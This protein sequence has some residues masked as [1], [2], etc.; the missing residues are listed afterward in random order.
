M[1][2]PLAAAT[3]SGKADAP[4]PPSGSPPRAGDPVL[5][6]CEPRSSLTKTIF[7]TLPAAPSP[8]H[9]TARP[10]GPVTATQAGAFSPAVLLHGPGWVTVLTPPLAVTITSSPSSTAATR[11]W[12][13]ITP[14]PAT[15]ATTCQAPPASG[16]RCKLPCVEQ[17]PPI[18]QGPTAARSWPS[19]PSSDSIEPRG[20]AADD[21]CSPPSVVYHR[22]LPNTNPSEG[23]ANRIPHTAGS[24]DSDRV[25]SGTTGAGSPRQLAPRFRVRRIDVHGAFAHGAVPRTN[26]SC[27]ETNVTDR[28]ANPI[29]TGPPAGTVTVDVLADV[30]GPAAPVEA[31]PLAADP[32]VALGPPDAAGPLDDAAGELA[33][34]PPAPELDAPQAVSGTA[35]SRAAPASPTRDARND[36]FMRSP[37]AAEASYG[38]GDA[39]AGSPVRGIWPNSRSR[40][41]RPA[42][43]G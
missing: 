26:A 28:A 38:Y 43:V 2:A 21:Q 18:G 12:V 39:R 29:G 11:A 33:A 4:D 24:V 42:N 35:A 16:R 34:A 23:L 25:A 5:V 3:P 7:P 10:V 36:V 41:P 20:E 6:Q 9:I 32:G 15:G 1:L 22:P 8:A 31:A 13:A 40:R 17:P 27:G 37:S 19:I 30:V 14:L